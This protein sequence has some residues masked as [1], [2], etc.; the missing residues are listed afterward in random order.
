MRLFGA[1]AI[2]S[3]VYTFT[4]KASEPKK[5]QA[6]FTFVCQWMGDEWRIIEHHSSGMSEQCAHWCK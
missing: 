4:F 5:V 2:N 3:G 1:I 6:R